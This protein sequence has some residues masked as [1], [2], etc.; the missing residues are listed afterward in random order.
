MSAYDYVRETGVAVTEISISIDSD[1]WL[2]SEAY[3]SLISDPRAYWVS[4]QGIVL[5]RD[6]QDA[7]DIEKYL[8]ANEYA[9]NSIAK[10]MCSDLGG[11]PYFVSD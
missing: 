8:R 3:A 2:R 5:V 10:G 9:I 4:V 11:S 1:S 6:D 7:C